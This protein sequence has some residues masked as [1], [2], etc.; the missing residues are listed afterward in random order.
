MIYDK[1]I[2]KELNLQGE[3][4]T[5][6]K[7]GLL[8]QFDP[9]RNADERIAYIK[10]NPI[11]SSN[12]VVGDDGVYRTVI[13]D[14]VSGIGYHARNREE[15]IIMVC[16]KRNEKEVYRNL[17][18]LVRL[19]TNKH[20]FSVYSIRGDDISEST[21]TSMREYAT[22]NSEVKTIIYCNE[23]MHKMADN[24]AHVFNAKVEKDKGQFGDN[25]GILRGENIYVSKNVYKYIPE[26]H[27]A[28]RY[29]IISHLRNII[30]SPYKKYKYVMHWN[31][32]KTKIM[33]VMAM[34]YQAQ[35]VID[36]GTW[37]KQKIDNLKASRELLYLFIYDNGS[38]TE[39]MLI[40]LEKN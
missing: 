29:Y 8:I 9:Q 15:I 26:E 35:V 27:L 36:D 30:I 11:K 28:F 7:I 34:L 33:D 21:L 4:K 13:E 22:S 3:T 14:D 2:Y 31:K 32:N 24:L 23:D 39:N 37:S 1:G 16:T 20:G 25:V 5:N 38:K 12:F 6:R 17:R 19:M 10:K 40:T 18:D